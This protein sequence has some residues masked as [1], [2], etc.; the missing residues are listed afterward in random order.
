MDDMYDSVNYQNAT[1]FGYGA[2]G[3]VKK[4]TLTTGDKS[5]AYKIYNP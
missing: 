1:M 5:G 3:E 2:K 4:V